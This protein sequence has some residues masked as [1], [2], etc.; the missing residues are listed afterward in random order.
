MYTHIHTYLSLSIYTY[1]YIHIHI[2]IHDSRQHHTETPEGATADSIRVSLRREVFEA[3]VP[4]PRAVG[5][6]NLSA[7]FGGSELLGSGSDHPD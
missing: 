3:R 5:H 6:L 2:Y 7:P 1:I 4:N